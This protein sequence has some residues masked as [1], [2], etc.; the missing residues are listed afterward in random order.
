MKKIITLFLLIGLLFSSNVLAAQRL[1]KDYKKNCIVR[2]IYAKELKTGKTQKF[3]STCDVPEGW[4][5]LGKW[6]PIDAEESRKKGEE[7]SAT[8][9]AS[10]HIPAAT[11]NERK[12]FIVSKDYTL[13]LSNSTFSSW[14]EKEIRRWKYTLIPLS[15]ASSG[16][17][18]LTLKQ[19]S[20]ATADE[21]LLL[22]KDGNTVRK[23]SISIRSGE[24]SV[25]WFIWKVIK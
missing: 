11:S 16:D 18:Y 8:I 6:T 1:P 14:M 4:V 24:K 5:L 19:T 2:E 7:I 13:T 23:I 25:D 21:V 17:I 20:Y 10:L 15:S 3:A 22:M 12:L 9:I